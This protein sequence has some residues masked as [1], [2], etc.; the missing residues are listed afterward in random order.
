MTIIILAV[1]GA[2]MLMAAYK[3]LTSYT[4]PNWISLYLIGG[5]AL[6]APFVGYGLPD[7]GWH[8]VSGIGA[9]ALM[10]GM[11]AMGWLGGGDAKL[12]AATALWCQ[13]ADLLLIYTPNVAIWGGALTLLIVFTRHSLPRRVRTT[14]WV[15]RL[16]RDE[17]KIPYGIALAAAGL[18]ALPKFTI[19]QSA[20]LG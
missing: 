17:D 5:F 1:F 9:L 12:F 13:P 16:L 8:L 18:M 4:I 10:M 14:G 7:I 6:I 19:F 2:A 11:F 15:Q 20:A 3:D